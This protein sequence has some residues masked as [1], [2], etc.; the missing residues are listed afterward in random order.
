MGLAGLA[1]ANL[2]PGL[3]PVI[4]PLVVSAALL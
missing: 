4:D 3:G 2:V 1:L